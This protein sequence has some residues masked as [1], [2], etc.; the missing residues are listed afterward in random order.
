MNHQLRINDPKLLHLSRWLLDEMQSNGA[1]GKLYIDS[2]ANRLA[3]HILQNYTSNAKRLK[4]SPSKLS[5]QQVA[6]AIEYVHANLERDNSLEE[7]TTVVNVSQSHLGRMFK[8]STGLSPHQYFIHLKVE[9]AKTI[10]KQGSCTMGEIAA[11]SDC[12]VPPARQKLRRC[13]HGR[14]IY[15]AW[16]R[17]YAKCDGQYGCRDRAF[18]TFPQ[19]VSRRSHCR[20]L[21]DRRVRHADHY[22][23]N[24]SV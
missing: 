14:R 15:R 2:L 9:K 5:D 8:Q 24:Q 10:M 12:P 1:G 19:S 4:D 3:I 16:T 21:P 7:L 11:A 23:H 20:S 22:N 6:R 18:W 17:C 13:R